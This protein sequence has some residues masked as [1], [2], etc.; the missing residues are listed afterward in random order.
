M[1][2][3]TRLNLRIGCICAAFGALLVVSVA[4]CSSTASDS[5]STA[6]D[7]AG[8]P[9]MTLGLSDLPPGS[10]RSTEPV[11][12]PSCKAYKALKRWSAKKF[13]SPKFETRFAKVQQS[14]I[15]FQSPA[16][17]RRT[18]H[19]MGSQE[20]RRCIA[21]SLGQMLTERGLAPGPAVT[22][23]IAA[24]QLDQLSLRIPVFAPFVG[25]VNVFVNL[26]IVTKKEK[27]WVL[28]LASMGAPTSSS[29]RQRL[30]D[31]AIARAL[32]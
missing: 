25:R 8:L 21:R 17:A 13:D 12:T 11:L 31:Q 29:F 3:L 9:G 32:T 30:R 20:N 6:S 14:Y 4:G 15:V 23:F 27:A 28:L 10:S 19:M 7:T 26:S 1:T 16:L 24:P 2:C 22:R 18:V 5:A